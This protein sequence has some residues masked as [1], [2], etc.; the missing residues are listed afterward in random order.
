MSA[1]DIH[2]PSRAQ[3]LAARGAIPQLSLGPAG[4]EDVSPPAPSSCAGSAEPAMPKMP[5]GMAGE[6]AFLPGLDPGSS[7]ESLLKKRLEHVGRG[8][9]AAHDDR[10]PPGLLARDAQAYII[11]ALFL[12]GNRL[13]DPDGTRCR[14]KLVNAGA[15]ILAAIEYHD[16]AVARREQEET[17]H[18]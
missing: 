16:R 3:R 12:T 7:I 11:D 6:A 2:F 10:L 1:V 14:L 15:L 17:D 9:D 5:P 4:R 18:A 8:Y 13:K